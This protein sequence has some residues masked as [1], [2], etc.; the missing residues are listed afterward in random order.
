MSPTAAALARLGRAAAAWPPVLRDL[1]AAGLALLCVCLGEVAAMALPL[2]AEVLLALPGVLLAGLVL[3]WPS[4]LFA[5]LVAA[6]TVT[7]LAPVGMPGMVGDTP[8]EPLK[9][10][11]LGLALIA[12][13]P[14]ARLW[15]RRRERR[16]DLLMEAC[17]QEALRRIATAEAE[18][19]AAHAALSRAEAALAEARARHARAS[20]DAAFQEARLREGGI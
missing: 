17:A 16:A 15:A 13:A 4:A 20:Q 19:R 6:A 3:G 8:A 10:A 11:A 5:L 2:P 9:L 1:G 14:A 12:A 7:A 18:T